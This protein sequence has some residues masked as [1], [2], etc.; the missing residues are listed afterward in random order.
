MASKQQWLE[1]FDRYEVIAHGLITLG[2]ILRVMRR[3]ELDKNL[4]FEQPLNEGWNFARAAR[5]WFAINP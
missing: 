1:V 3:Y 5:G 2:D 4:E